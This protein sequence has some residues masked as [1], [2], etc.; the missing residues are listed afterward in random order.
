M[1]DKKI[2]ENLELTDPLTYHDKAD[3][4]DT[5]VELVDEIAKLEK[6]KKD[7]ADVKKGEIAKK[8]TAL[9]EALGKIKKGERSHW[10]DCDILLNVPEDGQKTIT[11]LDLPADW[12]PVETNIPRIWVTNMSEE[13]Y[14]LFPE[15][16]TEKGEGDIF[17]AFGLE[18]VDVVGIA[19]SFA[20]INNIED[21]KMLGPASP[22]DWEELKDKLVLKFSS[23]AAAT[24]FIDLN[25]AEERYQDDYVRFSMSDKEEMCFVAVAPIP[26]TS[27]SSE[28]VNTET[29]QAFPPEDA[30]PD[31]QP[32]NV[33]VGD[34][35]YEVVDDDDLIRKDIVDDDDP[36]EE[37]ENSTR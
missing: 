9:D 12:D 32:D 18:E 8:T 22:G 25:L 27:E 21:M 16:A 31:K 14:R 3:L 5:A 6:E 17:L 36:P 1:S 15:Q 35:H 19:E 4:A 26:A 2:T 28:D 10:E 20:I 7:H 13:D 24:Q 29:E 37:A 34:Q 30:T 23:A 11:R 33:E